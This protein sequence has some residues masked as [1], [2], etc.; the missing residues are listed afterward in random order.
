MLVLRVV[1]AIAVLSIGLLAGIY[2]ADRAS[3]PAR[4]TLDPSS[5]VKY[6]QTVHVTYVKMM[7]PL[8]IAAI[9]AA[10]AWLFLV[11]LRWRGTEFW[12]VAAATCAIIL[13]AVMTRAVNVPLNNQLMTW[14]VA[15]P[16]ENL[17]ELWA[18]WEQVDAIRTVV[19]I[20]AFV[21]EA[22]ALCFLQSVNG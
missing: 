6:Q 4:A 21:V 19:A 9:I 15:A 1:R 12:L 10:A 14:S 20:G 8:V 7:P 11:R 2:L 18:R 5:F 16:P 22:C 3:A 17:K 13:I